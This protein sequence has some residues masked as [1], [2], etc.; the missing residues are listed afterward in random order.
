VL[1]GG[2]AG[3]CAALELADAG[4][5]VELIEREPVLISQASYW[6]EGKIHL[7]FTYVKDAPDR[8]ARAMIRGALRFRPLLER[9]LP[10]RVIDDAL[11]SPFE[12][13][14]PRDSMVPPAEV[15][16]HFARVAGIVA[17][18]SASPGTGYVAE[19]DQQLV[20]A[21]PRS[22]RAATYDEDEIVAAFATGERA[23]DPW[24]LAVALREVAA[25]APRVAIRSATT[26]LGVELVSEREAAVTTEWE[27]ER[28]RASYAAV[29]NALGPQRAAVDAAAGLRPR[30]RLLH[31][32]KVG[33]NATSAVPPEVPSV[34][35]VTGEYGDVVSLDSRA[36]LSW[37]PAGLLLTSDSLDPPP[38]AP[39]LEGGEHRRVVRETLSGIARLLPAI[40]P[41]G[42][43]AGAEWTVGGGYITALGTTGIDDPESRLHER[44][45][46]GVSSLGPLQSVDTAK[47]TLAPLYAHEASARVLGT[48]AGT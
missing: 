19:L 17:E 7:G 11:S 5:Q 15:A 37:Y 30:G 38:R 6:S 20:E 26:V 25:A 44:H 1:G 2:L 31:R 28:M 40:G 27:G 24:Q 13:A 47:L 9:W 45:Q 46:I 4:W 12:Y 39:M 8:T 33:L 34:T 42:A 10:A 14:V 21:L 3:V 36:I 48:R 43:R 18:E 32:Y 16:A 41:W 35:F 22:R 29:V 23:V